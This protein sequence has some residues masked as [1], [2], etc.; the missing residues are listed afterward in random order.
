MAFG[1]WGAF[2]ILKQWP[3]R[4]R[5]ERGAAVLTS[6]IWFRQTRKKGGTFPGTSRQIQSD[7]MPE[8]KANSIAVVGGGITGLTA[9]WRLHAQG[10]RVTLFEQSYRLGGAIMSVARDG[11]LCECGPNSMLESAQ[12]DALVTGLELTAERQYAEPAA[13]RRS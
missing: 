12:L 1:L 13:R 6:D 5:C 10:C 9:A 11:W 2:H 8:S 4:C 3:T 7:P